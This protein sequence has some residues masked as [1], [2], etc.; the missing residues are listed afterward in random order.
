MQV[1]ACLLG[2]LHAGMHVVEGVL[3]AGEASVD[4]IGSGLGGRAG[5][6]AGRKLG[7]GERVT[8]NEGMARGAALNLPQA[9]KI[10]AFEIAIAVLELP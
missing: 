8:M 1:G 7:G 9:D 4:G 6:R 2:A 3:E 10:A 5:G